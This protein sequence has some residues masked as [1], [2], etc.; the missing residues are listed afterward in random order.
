MITIQQIFRHKETGRKVIYR[1][2]C[3]F[4]DIK[5]D[6]DVDGKIYYETYVENIE[7][8]IYCEDFDHHNTY[9]IPVLQF[10]NYYEPVSNYV[11]EVL[12]AFENLKRIENEGHTENICALHSGESETDTEGSAE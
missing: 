2:L 1:G 5:Q 7:D 12:S 3:T 8:C 11:E 4:E 9:A 6:Q 10:M